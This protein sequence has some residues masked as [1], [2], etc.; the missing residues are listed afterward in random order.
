LACLK[1][2]NKRLPQPNTSG[3]RQ[4]AIQRT[5]QLLTQAQR[6]AYDV[7]QIDRAFNLD[8]FL[9]EHRA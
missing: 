9:A 2:A 7:Q 3:R 8:S 1:R 5:Q 6:I 4:S